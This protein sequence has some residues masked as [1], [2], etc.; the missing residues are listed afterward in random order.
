MQTKSIRFEK[1]LVDLKGSAGETIFRMENV[2]VPTTWSQTATTIFAQKYLK[3]GYEVSIKHTVERMV[4]TWRDSLYGS[5]NELLGFSREYFHEKVTELI[6]NQCFAPNSPQWFN[7][8]VGTYLG[9]AGDDNN[10]YYWDWINKRVEKS[11]K[12]F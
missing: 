5:C 9:F 1:R 6:I 3:R 4:S 2:E 7:T 12:D 10:H 8:G 11:P